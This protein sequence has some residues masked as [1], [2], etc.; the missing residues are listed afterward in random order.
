MNIHIFLEKTKNRAWLLIPPTIFS[1]L[2]VIVRYYDLLDIIYI[3]C[4]YAIT[5]VYFFITIS[6]ITWSDS[7][8]SNMRKKEKEQDNLEN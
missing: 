7:V 3:L 8:R 6:T 1:S 4:L 2:I 5:F